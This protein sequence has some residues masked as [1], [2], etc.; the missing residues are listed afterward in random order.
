MNKKP[1]NLGV[2]LD[3]ALTERL[4]RIEQKTGVNGATIARNAIEA[5]LNYFDKHGKLIFP[6]H[7]VDDEIF[8]AMLNE[9]PSGYKARNIAARTAFNAARASF[10]VLNDRVFRRP[11]TTPMSSIHEIEPPRFP[12]AR[13]FTLNE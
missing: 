11:S 7:I 5:A 1:R 8:I 3:P 9:K 2:R 4:A 13:I 10:S 12:L 6:L